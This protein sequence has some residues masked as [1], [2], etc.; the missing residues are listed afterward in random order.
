MGSPSLAS[1]RL[2]CAFTAAGIV[3][4]SP[5]GMALAAVPAAM[6][7]ARRAARTHMLAA[8]ATE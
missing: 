2:T 3:G 5:I 4:L 6:W 8:I 1:A 7:P